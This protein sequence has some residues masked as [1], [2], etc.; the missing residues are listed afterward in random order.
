MTPEPPEDPPPAPGPSGWVEDILGPDYQART[1]PLPEDEEGEVVATVV[2]HRP[3]AEE[4]RRAA[5]AVLYVHGWNDYFFQTGLAE[6]WHD[7]GAAFYA[8]D[9]RKYGRSL[10]PHHTPNYV[11]DLRTYDEDLEAAL[12]AVHE[13]LGPWAR[14]MLMGHS[15]GGLVGVLWARRNPGRV[16]GLVLNSPWLEL[17]GSSVMRT[18]STPVVQQL[19]RIQPKSPMLNI[20]PGFYSR[21]ILAEHGGEWTYDQAWRPTPYFPIRPG[22]L[23][24][25]LTG[26][27][28][29]AR[30]L[31]LPLPIFMAA[32]ARSLILP[33]W[34]EE[35]R[36]VDTVL[37]VDLLARRA[38]LL[39][40]LV[41]VVRIQ[42]GLH[43]LTLS[44]RPARERFY[45]ELSRWL[46][47]YGWD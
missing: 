8:V 9:L 11:A 19:A 41:T 42:G 39:G 26:H 13:D 1:L 3:A 37:D 45:G 10:R 25:I 16:T 18:L 34:R 46:T 28:Q 32:S 20:D 29:V 22:W 40:P 15:T 21:T 33:R 5:R 27:A 17:T 35:M 24:A 2:R 43:D 4:P 14:V 7:Q 38:V 31:D 6:Y 36:E 23:Q 47:A 12:A 44:A 30:G